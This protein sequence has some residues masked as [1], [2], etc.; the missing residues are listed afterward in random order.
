MQIKNNKFDILNSFDLD[1][2]RPLLTIFEDHRF[3][4]SHSGDNQFVH[5]PMSCGYKLMAFSFNNLYL[6]FSE[7]E[8][9]LEELRYPQEPPA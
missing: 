8:E 2:S 4:L 6:N 7:P 9:N 3:S 1:R 5:N